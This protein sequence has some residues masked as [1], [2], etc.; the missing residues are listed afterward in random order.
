[1]AEETKKQRILIADDDE[2]NLKLIIAMLKHYSYAFETAADGAEALAKAKSFKPDLIF[3]DI[4]MPKMDGYEV[5][6][7]LKEDAAT[8]QI[9]VVMVTALADKESRV[10]GLGMGANDFLSKPIDISELTIRTKNLL[11]IKEFE[12]FLKGYNELLEAEVGKKTAQLR[13]SYIDTIHK[14]TKVAEYKD[15]DTA[16]HIKRA[17]YYSE[18]LARELGW[19]AETVETIFYASPMHDIGKTGIPAEILL[20][21][22]KLTTEEFALMKT[23]TTIGANI[24]SG[25]TSGIIQMAEIIALSH[26]ERWDGAGYPRGLKGEGIPIEGRIYNI[27]DQYDALRSSRPYKYG[28]DHLKTFKI[29]TE[30]DGR[31]M[32]EHF[33]P[34]VLAAFKD[35]HKQFDE[36]YERYKG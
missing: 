20:K 35:I 7:R 34:D 14:L 18:F 24:L 28:F 4:M 16:S 27:C 12:D 8:K 11:K 21:P 19:Q 2:V 31:T 32:P 33:D 9:P 36:I 3:L 30:G 29:I 26:H 25:R 23:H 13:E 5:C 1:M 17:G 15:E 6:K 22:A 10:K